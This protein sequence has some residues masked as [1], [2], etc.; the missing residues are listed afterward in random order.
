MNSVLVALAININIAMGR[1]SSGCEV[2][3]KEIKGII[4]DFDGVLFDSS[5]LHFEAMQILLAEHGVD[6]SYEIYKA[7][8]FGLNDLVLLQKLLPPSYLLNPQLVRELLQRKIKLYLEKTR[9]NLSFPAVPGAL[10]FLEKISNHISARAVFSNGSERE[11]NDA[12][13]KLE[14]GA[15][16][17]YFQFVTTIQDVTH[18][19]PDPEGYL[20]SAK[21]LNID[22]KFC[23]VIEDSLEGI[24]AAKSA[25]MQVI[26]LATTYSIEILKP[27]V[28][29][30]AKDYWAAWDFLIGKI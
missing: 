17:P 26:G 30:A 11:V 3:N 4:F 1:L 22:P 6:L 15:I 16:R 24:R 27:H 21:K 20:L 7:K 8:Y 14:Q 5:F 13:N 19:K 10:N 18:G 9:N 25:G 23:L 28:D 12:L 2:V 29:F